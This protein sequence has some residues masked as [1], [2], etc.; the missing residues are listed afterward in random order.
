MIKLVADHKIPFLQGVLEPYAKVDYHSGSQISAKMV[1]NADALL[2]RTRTICNKDL[3]EGSAVKFIATATIGYDH[4]DTNYCNAKGI[5]WANAPGCNSGSVMQYIAAALMRLSKTYQFELAEKTI[6]IIG[7]GMVG[8]K[9]ARL[10][11]AL[12]MNV[13]IN[14]P[15]LQRSGCALHFVGLAELVEKSD[16][17]SLHV[18]LNRV[19]VDKTWHLVNKDFLNA[20]KPSAFLINTSRGEVV[21]TIALKNALKTKQIRASI[22]DVWENEPDIDLELMYAVDFAT[23]HIAGYSADGKANGT[24]MSVRAISNHFGF[25]L[26]N[27]FPSEIP[28]PENIHL[29]IDCNEKSRQEVV[30]QVILKTYDIGSDDRRL[31]NSP[32][33]FEVQRG[34][35]PLRREFQVFRPT[36]IKDTL[37]ITNILRELGFSI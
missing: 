37:A 12:G 13:L 34:D 31:R 11:N 4:I 2:I 35:Y 36:L 19:G 3:L 10:A 14:D 8:S 17:I 32:Q 33:T 22:L 23:P 1:K 15:P 20:L 5:K 30:S 6:G 9:V 26:G 16:L 24:A 18:P 27:W 7:H 21:D 29:K 28:L 25:G